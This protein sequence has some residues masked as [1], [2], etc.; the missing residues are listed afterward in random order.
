LQRD[1]KLRENGFKDIYMEN[2]KIVH[3]WCTFESTISRMTFAITIPSLQR[4]G[5]QR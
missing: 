5:K 2:K 4:V 3:S 1:R